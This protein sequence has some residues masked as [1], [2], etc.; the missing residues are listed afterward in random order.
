MDKLDNMM[1]EMKIAGLR[2]ND[3]EQGEIKHKMD[4]LMKDVHARDV[5]I[6]RE[7][8]SISKQRERV[9]DQID[10]LELQKKNCTSIWQRLKLNWKIAELDVER[11]GLNEQESR[12]VGLMLKNRGE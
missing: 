11:D 1:L 4:A 8:D 10:A 6:R 9:W 12:Q 5:P 3:V 2:G 7:I